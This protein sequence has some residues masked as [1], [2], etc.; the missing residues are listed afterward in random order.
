MLTNRT[1]NDPGYTPPS[2]P[3]VTILYALA[4]TSKVK[5]DYRLG[6]GNSQLEL[7]LI[8]TD[9]WSGGW[10]IQNGLLPLPMPMNDTGWDTYNVAGT[11]VPASRPRIEAVFPGMYQIA[12]LANTVR[13]AD[14]VT[15]QAGAPDDSRRFVVRLRPTV[16]QEIEP[17]VRAY[18]DKCAGST[19]L[20]PPGC[21]FH[22]VSNGPVTDV[23]WTIT[24]YP[25]LRVQLAAGGEG[26]VVGQ[27]G[28]AVVTG[29][30]DSPVAPEFAYS[31]AFSVSGTARVAEG[32]VVFVP[33]R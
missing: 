25:I 14:P 29:R 21:P 18:L 7:T 17:Q 8:R 33:T 22:G 4:D 5:V 9:G 26:F 30:T 3:K 27:A 20:E 32:K 28:A 31:T 1:L 11:L 19:D 16:L 24:A 23:N 15:V 13:E 2:K 10:T 12:P 6:Q